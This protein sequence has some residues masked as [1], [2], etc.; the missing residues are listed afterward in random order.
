MRN[1]V[2]PVVRARGIIKDFIT[3]GGVL[4][5]L[6]GCDLNVGKG[7][8]V[9]VLGASGVG[10]STLL[11]IM[12]TLDR[13]TAGSVEFGEEDVF[14]LSDHARA[15]FRNRRI[16]FVFQFH[17]LMPEFTALENVMMPGLI[18]RLPIVA[19]RE[20][21]RV[22]LEQVGLGDRTGHKPHELSGGEQQRVAVARALLNDPVLVIADEPSGNLDPETA[23][24]LHQLVYT[25]AKDRGQ[26]WL[27]ATHNESL[28]RV[29]DRRSRL[30]QGRLQT[31]EAGEEPAAVVPAGGKRDS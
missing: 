7:E 18:A 31:D 30:V 28:A 1:D 5:V 24:R 9:A 19:A 20:K 16:G 6:R 25:L 29:A 21:A 12:G 22:L 11:H 8:I 2:P 15:G 23:E 3:P 10:K 13:P 26:S 4:H 17:H 14:R 27:I